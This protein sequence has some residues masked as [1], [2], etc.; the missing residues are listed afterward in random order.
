MKKTKYVLAALCGLLLSTVSLAGVIPVGL[1]DSGDELWTLT[2]ANSVFDD[3]GFEMLFEYGQFNTSDHTF[4]FYQVDSDNNKLASLD[5]FRAA[6]SVGSTSNLVWDLAGNEAS[7]KYGI[8]NLDANLAFGFYFIS[9]DFTAYSQAAL[10]GGTDYMDFFWQT[11]QFDTNNLY[12]SAWDND[13]GRNYDE[14]S[15]GIS[16]VSG[17]AGGASID[18]PEPASAALLGLGLLGMRLRHKLRG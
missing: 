9:D 15:I 13:T 6:D 4:G 12:V 1:T 5:L 17:F 16:D 3:S 2:D 14:V 11:D 7:T 8:M 10:N 18:V